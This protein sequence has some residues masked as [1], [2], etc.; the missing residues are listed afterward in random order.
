MLLGTYEQAR[1]ALVAEDDA[2]GFRAGSSGARPR[3]HRAVARDRLPAFPGAAAAP[4]SA[5]SSTAPSPSRP[6][7]IRW[8]GRCAGL[9]NFWCACAVM[10]GFSQG[11][12]VGLA[13]VELDDRR[14]S[15]LRR[16]GHG[17]RPLRDWAT[18]GYTNAKVRENYARRFRIRFPNEELPAARPMQTT[19]L[20]DRMLAQGAVMGDMLGARDAALVRAE[21]RRGEGHRLLPPLQRF[22]ACAGARCLAV[23]ESVGVTEIANF[24]KYA[25]TGSGAEAFLSRLMTNRMPKAGRIVLTPMLN[26]RGKLIGDFTIAKAA[27]DGAASSCGGRARRRSITCAGSSGTCPATARCR[28]APLGM[29]LVGL[30]IAGPNRAKLL[31]KLTDEDV[32]TEALH[33]P[34]FPRD[35]SRRVPVMVEPRHLYRRPRLRDL[36]EAGIPAPALREGDG[37]GRGIRHREFRHARPPL[38]AA[39]EELADLVSRAPADLRAVRGRRRPLRRSEEERLHRPRGGGAGEGRRRQAPPRHLRRRCRRRRR[40]RRRAD[41]AATE[42]SSAGSL[43]AAMPTSSTARWRRAICRSELATNGVGGFEIEILGE[44]RPA[45]IQAEPL[46]DPE[47]ARMRG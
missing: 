39:R 36:G 4:A 14:R 21:G 3:P 41:L 2:V 43:R 18:L 27:P 7:A 46:F 11:G 40:A 47:G 8:S 32:S 35:A 29:D 44:R 9:K 5:R 34:G 28:S 25:I 17:R 23:R 13:L 42:R 37:G 24:A 6:T 22:S 12:G 33:V 31:A 16:L 10:A 45:R 19:P 38:A 20:Y 1:D 15:G 26:E 30:S